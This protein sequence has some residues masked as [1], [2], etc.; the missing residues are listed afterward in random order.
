MFYVIKIYFCGFI[1]ERIKIGLLQRAQ[2]EAALLPGHDGGARWAICGGSHSHTSHF[3]ENNAYLIWA[4]D[5]I[6]CVGGP[7]TLLGRSDEWNCKRI[8][9]HHN[10]HYL[11]KHGQ[12]K[13]KQ[14]HR[15]LY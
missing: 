11:L 6:F 10:T 15:E 8:Q 1:F 4:C 7:V 13:L 14:S 12:V 3:R 2:T 5:K 9:I